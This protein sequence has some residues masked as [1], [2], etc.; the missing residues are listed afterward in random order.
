M[1]KRRWASLAGA[2]LLTVAGPLTAQNAQPQPDNLEASAG[3]FKI[4]H[5]WTADPEGFMTAWEGPTPPSLPTTTRIERNQRLTQAIL[6]VNCTKDAAGDCHLGATVTMTAPDG[7]AYGEP[8]TFDA[9]KG[10]SAIAPNVIGLSR[11]GIG[12]MIEDGEQLGLYR[13]VLAVTDYNSG[14]VATS[15]VH[16]EAVEEGALT[17]AQ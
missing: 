12:L 17:D 11:A 9:L 3:D 5:L 2:L 14:A 4:I 15:I 8:F 10:P 6:Y 1:I 13:V 7:T 16:L